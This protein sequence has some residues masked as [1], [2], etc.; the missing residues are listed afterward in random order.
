MHNFKLTYELSGHGW[1]VAIVEFEGQNVSMSVSYLHDSLEQLTSAALHLLRN[2][3]IYEEVYFMG[4]PGEYELILSREE[5]LLSGLIT[6]FDDWKSWG[7][8]DESKH[9]VTKQL[10]FKLPVKK[11][12]MEVLNILFRLYEQHGLQGYKNMW[13]EHEFPLDKYRR[14]EQAIKAFK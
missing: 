2:E 10:E 14:L 6:W 7:M 3:S 5:G 1:A 12:A 9:R 11:F 4:E 8:F 13:V